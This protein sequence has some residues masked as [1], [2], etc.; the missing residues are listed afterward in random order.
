[1][2]A[3]LKKWCQWTQSSVQF[4]FIIIIIII[5]TTVATVPTKIL[6]NVKLSSASFSTNPTNDIHG[7]GEK[8]PVFLNFL[9][10]MEA[11]VSYTT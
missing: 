2:V 11:A 7:S 6:K 8:N 5:I 1:M 3:Y 10:E 9:N 4:N